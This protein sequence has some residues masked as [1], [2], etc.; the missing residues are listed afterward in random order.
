MTAF[1][2]GIDVF[3]ISSFEPKRCPKIHNVSCL[4]E[5]EIYFQGSKLLV[6]VFESHII[7][8]NDRQIM[9]VQEVKINDKLKRIILYKDNILMNHNNYLVQIYKIDIPWMQLTDFPPESL[10]VFEDILKEYSI[11]SDSK[12][13][14]KNKP[15]D[16][17]FIKTI[18]FHS[19]DF[20]NELWTDL[21]KLYQHSPIFEGEIILS[22][23]TNIT[24]TLRGLKITEE[25]KQFGKYLSPIL[26]NFEHY[27]LQNLTLLYYKLEWDIK[28]YI[29][30]KIKDKLPFEFTSYDFERSDDNYA[31]IFNFY[32]KLKQNLHSD[33]L[34][35]WVYFN[36][37]A[38]VMEKLEEKNIHCYLMMDSRS[39]KLAH[40]LITLEDIN[41]KFQI[42]KKD[43]MWYPELEKQREEK[44]RE[45]KEKNRGKEKPRK[46]LT[47]DKLKTYVIS[48][49]RRFSILYRETDINNI[50]VEIPNY[51]YPDDIN[52]QY[53]EKINALHDKFHIHQ[54]NWL[55]KYHLDPREHFSVNNAIEFGTK[56]IIYWFTHIY[57][58]PIN[59]NMVGFIAAN[60]DLEKLKWFY[61][62]YKLLPDLH[63]LCNAAH[64]G[65]L[66][67]LIWAKQY[68]LVL[69]NYD[70]AICC[71]NIEL[72][73]WMKN[74]G[75]VPEEMDANYAA[76]DGHLNVLIWLSQQEPSILPS[77]LGANW[78]V[79][80]KQY[81][82]FEWLLE[83]NI[84][85]NE[86]GICLA[87]GRGDF[88]MA[89]RLEGMG[90]TI[91]EEK[92]KSWTSMYYQALYFNPIKSV[93]RET[94]IITF[95]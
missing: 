12:Y 39:N 23:G 43:P 63:G 16:S 33:L 56:A 30:S 74:N 1:K 5:I 79:G 64:N 41:Y 57:N 24:K 9:I 70:H 65:Y 88:E 35:H 32:A 71:G 73:E 75:A 90:I 66:D 34:T 59:S 17:N 26:D 21:N 54:F 87:L 10:R 6:F 61:S 42:K 46:V 53:L 49:L 13:D 14:P 3:E 38:R 8:E 48:Q 2:P 86:S 28:D 47:T 80:D 19:E 4:P 62:T 22:D 78:T 45:K 68:N 7:Y 92:R 37:Y 40:H 93:N 11:V 15:I 52:P 18:L 58:R 29:L 82:C 69:K 72:L 25:K 85:P 55:N 31:N 27:E 67:I 95:N 51:D 20:S 83:R 50:K 77:S 44:E 76:R 60:G 84:L 81:D 91:S 36:K 89:K 94:G